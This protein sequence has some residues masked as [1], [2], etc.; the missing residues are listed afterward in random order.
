MVLFLFDYCLKTIFLGNVVNLLYDKLNSFRL[1]KLP[2]SDGNV[3][4]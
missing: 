4:N 3:V 1:D 2:I